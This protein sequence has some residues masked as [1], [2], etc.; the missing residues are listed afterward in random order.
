MPFPWQERTA[1]VNVLTA[2]IVSRTEPERGRGG[3]RFQDP[4]AGPGALCPLRP[5]IATVAVTTQ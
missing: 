1:L 2:L 4:W 5:H 3:R